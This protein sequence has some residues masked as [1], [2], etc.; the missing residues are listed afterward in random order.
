MAPVDS[1]HNLQ[2]AVRVQF[3]TPGI[4]PIHEHR[5]LFGQSYSEKSIECEGGVS[6]PG[7]SVIPIAAASDYFR[8][9][10]GRRRDNGACR[11]IS[12]QLERQRGAL[13]HLAPAAGVGTF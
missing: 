10:T 1:V 7:V 8:K 9:T 5:R 12:E 13:N 3:V 2:G 6:N 11:R 4:H